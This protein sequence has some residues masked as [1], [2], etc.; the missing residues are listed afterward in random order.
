MKHSWLVVLALS[1]GA[2]V[3]AGL[4]LPPAVGV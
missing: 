3:L 2:G 1:A 4:M